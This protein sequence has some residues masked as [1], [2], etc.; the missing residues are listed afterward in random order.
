MAAAPR[1]RPQGR[2]AGAC[3]ASG[4]GRWR[5]GRHSQPGGCRVGPGLPR[6]AGTISQRRRDAGQRHG[7]EAVGMAQGAVAAG[8]HRR[9]CAGRERYAVPGMRGRCGVAAVVDQRLVC[10]D[11][12]RL[13]GPCCSQQQRPGHQ[14]GQQHRQGM[15]QTAR[16]HSGNPPTGWRLCVVTSAQR[17]LHG[18]RQA[19]A[20]PPAAPRRRSRNGRAAAQRRALLD[21]DQPLAASTSGLA[22]RA[23]SKLWSQNGATWAGPSSTPTFRNRSATA[24]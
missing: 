5:I 18:G 10:R 4:D 8:L 3:G 16:P 19:T 1:G 13:G 22:C 9:I 21:L 6:Q 15:T 24:W 7:A 12:H 14:G 20:G 11:R 17:M 2:R 23:L